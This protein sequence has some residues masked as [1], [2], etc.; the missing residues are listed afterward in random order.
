MPLLCAIQPAC[1]EYRIIISFPTTAPGL[2]NSR[3]TSPIV[4]APPAGNA[5]PMPG[6]TEHNPIVAGEKVGSEA[7]AIQVRQFGREDLWQK[8]TGL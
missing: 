8:V 3:D 2:Q 1:T 7:E 6:A 5:F 4:T